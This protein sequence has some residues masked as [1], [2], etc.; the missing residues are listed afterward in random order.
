MERLSEFPL[1]LDGLKEE[2]DSEIIYYYYL[3]DIKG[4]LIPLHSF[5]YMQWKYLDVPATV[6]YQKSGSDF[7]QQTVALVVFLWNSETRQILGKAYTAH[8]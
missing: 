1:P 3:R 6:I 4:S 7:S 5:H 8:D 2:C